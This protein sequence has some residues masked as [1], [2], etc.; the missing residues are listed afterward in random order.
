MDHVEQNSKADELTRI[1]FVERALEAYQ[2]SVQ[3]TEGNVQRIHE[4]NQQ[5]NDQINEA[6]TDNEIQRNRLVKRAVEA[7]QAIIQQTEE[8]VQRVNEIHEQN[9][10]LLRDRTNI[11]EQVTTGTHQAVN[12]QAVQSHQAPNIITELQARLRERTNVTQQVTAGTH[13]AVNN[14]AAGSHQAPNIRH[15]LNHELQLAFNSQAQGTLRERIQVLRQVLSNERIAQQSTSAQPNEHA[16]R[17]YNRTPRPPPEPE[18][19]VMRSA[20]DRFRQMEI[21]NEPNYITYSLQR[22]NRLIRSENNS[23]RRPNRP[24]S[25]SVPPRIF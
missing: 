7:Y 3:Q 21:Q 17:V 12:D 10:D 20:L 6:Q 18:R 13:Q 9:N 22:P 2:A 16:S 19:N 14:Q 5:N 4:N 15:Q 25:T 23:L 24:I 8:N 1:R 11:T